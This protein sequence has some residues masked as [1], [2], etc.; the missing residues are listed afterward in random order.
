M[1]IKPKCYRYYFTKFLNIYEVQLIN[2]GEITKFHGKIPS[3]SSNVTADKPRERVSCV[4]VLL[5]RLQP[6]LSDSRHKS[7]VIIL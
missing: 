1:V 5:L 7:E 4:R 3:D 6:S 2:N